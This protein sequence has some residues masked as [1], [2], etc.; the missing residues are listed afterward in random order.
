LKVTFQRTEKEKPSY[1]EGEVKPGDLVIVVL[2]PEKKS[3]K[4]AFTVCVA[5]VPKDQ[6]KEIKEEQA[7][8]AVDAVINKGLS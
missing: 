1:W 4:G 7:K 3:S 2:S 8:M 5:T 6:P